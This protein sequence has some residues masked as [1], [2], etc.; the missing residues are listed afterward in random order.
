MKQFSRLC[1]I[2][3]AAAVGIGGGALAKAGEIVWS[4]QMR[5][6]DVSSEKTYPMTVRFAGKIG[7]SDYPE[8]ECGG[9][10]KRIGSAP[11]G[12]AIY[13]EKITRGA[14]QHDD[15]GGCINGVVIMSTKGD[16]AVLGWFAS[17]DG[18]PMLASATLSRAASK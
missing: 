11:G 3:L 2:G 8:L 16:K 9:T 10:W 14:D 15:K 17:L 7:Y 5:Q 13:L 12:Y 18:E 4:G 1:L 6:V